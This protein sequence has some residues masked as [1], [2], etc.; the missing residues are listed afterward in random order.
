MLRGV[1]RAVLPA[2]EDDVAVVVP[3][4]VHDGHGACAKFLRSFLTETIE[5]S[6]ELLTGTKT[7]KKVG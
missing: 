4:R 5:Q 2:A 7:P 1:V 6:V 3:L